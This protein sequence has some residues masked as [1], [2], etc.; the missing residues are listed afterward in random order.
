MGKR[1]NSEGTVYQRPDGRWCAQVTFRDDTG[2][3]RRKTVYG[4]TEREVVGKKRQMDRQR[5]DGQTLHTRRAPTLAEYGRDWICGRLADEVTLGRLRSST[6]DSYGGIWTE[7][8]EP[9][10]GHFRL[11]ALRATHILRWVASLSEKE[12]ARGK[13]MSDRT[14]QYIFAV[15]R[16]ALN[17]AVRDDLVVRNP[18]D[19]VR[20]PTVRSAKIGTSLTRDE[21]AR[22][23][24][25]LADESDAALWILQVSLGLRIGES[26]AL[27]WSD[28]ELERGRLTV[29]RSVS[30]V[31]RETD[32]ATGKRR[33]ELEVHAPKTQR[34]A[35]TLAMPKTLVEALRRHRT[36]QA[37]AR[38]AAPLWKEHDLVFPST[39]GTL[40]DTRNV[41]RRWTVLR[42]KSGIERPVRVHDL[43]HS[44]ATFLLTAGVPM[45]VIMET[46]RHTRIA[47]TADLYAHV[48]EE[49]QRAAADAME[50]SSQGSRLRPSENSPACGCST[51]CSTR[52]LV[53]SASSPG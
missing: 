45:K 7:H 39:I 42:A 20:G 48:A 11:D 31:R 17:D 12:S 30:R 34:S 40:Q 51:G 52:F 18:C 33:T 50:G 32:A 36:L 21:A 53:R 47:T 19:Q 1:A 24:A 16:R 26:L 43:R 14:K 38:L 3:V 29:A 6:A 46:L 2:A 4:I 35:A 23:M 27:R 9:A 25:V 13:P 5:E 10:L 44:T 37:K 49:V 8:I 28:L 15:L 41:A 22:L